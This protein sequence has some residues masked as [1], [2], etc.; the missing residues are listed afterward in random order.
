M[1]RR[2]RAIEFVPGS[3]PLRWRRYDVSQHLA[4]EASEALRFRAIEGDLDLPDGRHGSTIEGFRRRA[5]LIPP[6]PARNAG[7][8]PALQQEVPVAVGV[9]L[10]PDA[11]PGRGQPVA[12][13]VPGRV[14]VVAVASRVTNAA[15]DALIVPQVSS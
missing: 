9:L 11:E 2:Q 10:V 1:L 8:S 4:P 14:V 15:C 6:G 3:K 12:G 13:L 5:G 7:G